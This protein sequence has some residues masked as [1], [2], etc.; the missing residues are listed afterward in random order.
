[1]RGWGWRGAAIGAGAVVAAGLAAAGQWQGGLA[2]AAVIAGGGFLAPEVSEWLKKRQAEAVRRTEA[3]RAAHDALDEASDSAVSRPT[4]QTPMGDVFWLRPDQ[5]VV[6]FIDRPELVALR[7]WC[8]RNEAPQVMRLTGTGGVGK[9][10]LALQLAEEQQANGWLCRLVH[11]GREADV[12][13][14]ARAVSQGPVLLIVD[15][16]ET[17]PGLAALLEKV[18]GDHDNWLR[19]LLI[20]R[21]TGEWWK[22]LEASADFNVRTLIAAAQHVPVGVLAGA[23]PSDAELVHKAIPEFARVLGVTVSAQ[24]QVTVPEEPVPILVLHAAALLAVLRARDSPQIEALQVVAD[25]EVLKG[26]LTREA[27][28]WQGSAEMAGISGPTGLDLEMTAQAVAVACL[29]TVADESEAEQA[30]GRIPSL[31]DSR[32]LRIRT[33]RWLRQLYPADRGDPLEG[34]ARWWGSLQPDLLAELH[35]VSELAAAPVLARACLKDLT[36]VQAREAL[37]V[38]A[39]SCAHSPEAP[40]ILET[41]LRADLPGLGVPAVEVAVQTGRLGK[42]LDDALGNAEAPLAT[43]IQIEE[44]VPYPTVVLAQAAATLAVRIGRMLPADV[45]LPQIA[46]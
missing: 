44:A 30:L 35:A 21:S 15:Y 7:E 23:V 46:L 4:R 42:I 8:A 19:V 18:A 13:A 41:A 43:L 14:A 2:G 11:K 38:L 12:V 27:W 29:I 10:R 37:T 40:G 3:E 6:G 36:A 28:F 22:R 20:A 31:D 9:T 32:P 17:R 33:A 34:S 5:R 16:A 24:I 45:D 39:R 26:L 1:V 25:K